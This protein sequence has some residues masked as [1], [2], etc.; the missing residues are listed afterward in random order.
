M[1]RPHVDQLDR[2]A[3]DDQA[4]VSPVGDNTP[5]MRTAPVNPVLPAPAGTDPNNHIHITEQEF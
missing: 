1:S 3:L 4:L 2:D 5:D